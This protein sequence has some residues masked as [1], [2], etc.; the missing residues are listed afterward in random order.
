MEHLVRSNDNLQTKLDRVATPMLAQSELSFDKEDMLPLDAKAVE[1]EADR[2]LN[3]GCDGVNPSDMAPALVA[4]DARIITTHRMIHADD[5][6]VA[7]RGLR[8]TVLENDEIITEIQIAAPARRG[9]VCLREVRL[10]KVD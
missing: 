3:C 6:W 9:Q 7:D 5:F 4:L 1:M 10:E 2:C 8:P